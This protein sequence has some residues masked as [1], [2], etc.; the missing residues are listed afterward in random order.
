MFN[1]KHNLQEDNLQVLEIFCEFGR[2]AMEEVHTKPFQRLIFLI[3]DW[4]YPYNHAYGFKG[5]ASLLE[6]VLKVND[7]MPEQLQRV[8]RRVNDC[9]QE[10]EC[11]L[12]PHPGKTVATSPVFD[13]RVKDYDEQFL[14][15]LKDFVTDLLSPQRLVTKKIGGQQVTGRALLEYFKAYSE[16]FAGNTMPEPKTILEATAEAN[17]LTAVADIQ[18]MYQGKLE[19]LCGSKQ[20]YINP[21]LLVER[22]G[23]IEAECLQQ[24]ES[25][26]KMGG[27]EFTTPYRER[28]LQSMGHMFSEYSAL[29]SRKNIFSLVGVP[30]LLV[31]TGLV[32]VL[33]ARILESLGLSSLANAVNT[34][35]NCF[36]ALVALYFIA[37]YTGNFPGFVLGIERSAELGWRWVSFYTASNL[38]HSRTASVNGSSSQMELQQQQEPAAS[39]TSALVRA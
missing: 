22:N 37:R 31:V 36:M 3:R 15:S 29:N 33:A 21:Q 34:S 38:L 4:S 5:G 30:L 39:R 2:L 25:I 26:A 6:A 27:E 13:G 18:D 20:P 7:K 8:R 19:T 23:A 32:L 17:N 9:F 28:L 16:I 35:G 24:F 14:K 10:L 11:F 12:M 1:L